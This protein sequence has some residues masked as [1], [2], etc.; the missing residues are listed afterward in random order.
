MKIKVQSIHFDADTKLVDYV[1]E[2]AEKLCRFYEH[3]VDGEIFLKLER[4]ETHENKL[5][6]F[7]IHV[8]GKILFSR[9]MGNSFENA[10]DIAFEAMEKQVKKE[11]DRMRKL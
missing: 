1:T 2:K 9:E 10:A 7:K 11:K 8:P 3:I 4:S 6:E 5:V